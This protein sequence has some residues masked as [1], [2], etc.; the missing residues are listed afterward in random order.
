MQTL[1]DVFITVPS[2]PPALARAVTV[3]VA[4]VD[5]VVGGASAGRRTVVA[6]GSNRTLYGEHTMI[7]LHRRE[8]WFHIIFL[9][10]SQN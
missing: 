8:A 7:T 10:D 3:N 5:G 1:V 6:V 4:A 2:F 9:Q